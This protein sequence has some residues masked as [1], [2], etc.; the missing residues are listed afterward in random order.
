MD[1]LH[2]LAE[3]LK[4]KNAIDNLIAALINRPAL[5]GHTGEYIASRVFQIELEKSA[6]HKAIDGRFKEG[7]LGGCTVNVKWYTKHDG[8]LAVSP[9]DQ[10]RYYLV[11]A[12]PR[13]APVSSVG[14]T[15]PWSIETVFLFDAQALVA[16]LEKRGTKLSVATSVPR[17]FWQAA[18]IYPEQR[19]NALV[20]T[21][22]QKAQLALFRFPSGA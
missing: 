22:E 19:N 13:T 12:G 4:A 5:L 10:P 16:D 21:N 9:G 2:R 11:L 7:G 14:T 20:L 17:D 18:E 3:L 15:R 1:D 6:S 8:L